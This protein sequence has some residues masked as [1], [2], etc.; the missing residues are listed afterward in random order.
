M[1]E[2][3]KKPTTE[4]HVWFELVF[5]GQN[6]YWCDRFTCSEEGK[7]DEAALTPEQ[8]LD[9]KRCMERLGKSV[10]SDKRLWY[11]TERRTSIER[12]DGEL[13][14]VDCGKIVYIDPRRF[15]TTCDCGADYNGSGARLTDRA[16]W[17]EET[18]ET[19]ADI[20]QVDCRSSDHW[21]GY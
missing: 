16:Q 9:F 13:K 15:T 2:W 4:F 10:P 6:G 18:G 5:E 12:E 3:I 7:V 11:G 21:E 19:A 8:W 14:C 17:G 20:L 1:T